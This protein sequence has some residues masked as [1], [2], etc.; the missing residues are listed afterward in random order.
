MSSSGTPMDTG[1]P[2]P[3]DPPTPLK[4]TK[5]QCDAI[6]AMRQATTEII[7]Q[8]NIDCDN[9]QNDLEE[10]VC[11]AHADAQELIDQLNCDCE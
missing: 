9:P 11:G 1:P 8:N 3:P 6:C 10:T 4:V 2:D 7:A 5:K